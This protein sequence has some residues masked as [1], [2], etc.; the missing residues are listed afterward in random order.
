MSP[1]RRRA[2]LGRARWLAIAVQTLVSFG[3]AHAQDIP[4]SAAEPNQVLDYSFDDDQVL[5]DGVSPNGQWLTARKRGARESLVRARM[6]FVVELC[7]AIEQ[8]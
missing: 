5:A 3:A 1:L 8:L 4:R 7:R 2:Q 6:H